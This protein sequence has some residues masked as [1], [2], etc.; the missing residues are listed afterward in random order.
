MPAPVDA[1]G[2]SVAVTRGT[3][4]V[5]WTDST[6]DPKWSR[7][8]TSH[9]NGATWR[10]RRLDAKPARLGTVVA[11]SGSTVV[12]A[13]LRAPDHA[14][15]ARLSLDGGAT[16]QAPKVIQPPYPGNLQLEYSVAARPDRVAVAWTNFTDPLVNVRVAARDLWA[17]PVAVTADATVSSPA[18]GYLHAPI[19]KLIADTRVGI[20]FAGCRSDAVGGTCDYGLPD[21]VDDVLWAESQTNGAGWTT[22]V[23]ISPATSA[24]DGRI[25]PNT[26]D[27]SV[28]WTSRNLRA[29]LVSR[30]SGEP[31]WFVRN[32]FTRGY[33]LP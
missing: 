27:I 25:W 10:L 20:A 30:S 2:A 19:V 26:H 16:W 8:A 13:W 21:T 28:A 9:D 6:P 3:I 5:S 7:I 29:V 14:L 18:Y 12:T 15:I 17:A 33:G 32:F 31:D 1:G 24:A 4:F 11:A 22:P 23:V